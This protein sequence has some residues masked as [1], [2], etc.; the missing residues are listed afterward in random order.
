MVDP[1]INHGNAPG[2]NGF[3]WDESANGGGFTVGSTS[4]VNTDFSVEW[5]GY[6]YL[7]TGTSYFFQ[8]QSDD[9]SWLY[10][11]TSPGSSTIPSTVLLN[12]AN[13]ANSNGLGDGVQPPTVADSGAVTVTSSGWYPIEVQYYE[14]CDSQ[15]GID[16]SW[17]TGSVGNTYSI[18]PTGDF[19]PAAI[20]S[21][22]EFFPPPT[23]VPQFGAAAPAVAAVG[24]LAAVLMRRKALGRVVP[25]P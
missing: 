10:I 15:S 23:G 9:G 17:T 6:V 12:D 14:T 22:A 18:I 24:L 2:G 25:A 1:N 11:N 20:G 7:L 21:N 5:T 19:K 13:S 8:L 16:L 3:Y 4:F